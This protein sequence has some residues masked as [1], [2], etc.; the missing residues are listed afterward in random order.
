MPPEYNLDLG[1][2]LERPSKSLDL[3][4]RP[5]G[6][7]YVYG[8]FLWTQDWAAG[9]IKAVRA[10]GIVLATLWLEDIKAGPS[11]PGTPVGT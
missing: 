5:V 9:L 10:S 6:P 2:F 1:P 8:S 3:L 4:G 11:C 7:R